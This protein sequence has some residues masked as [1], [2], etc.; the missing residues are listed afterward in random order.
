MTGI[1]C[2]LAG[3]SGSTGT[4][5]SVTFTSNGTWVAPA[6]VSTVVS[7]SGKGAAGVSDYGDSTGGLY[8]A[9]QTGSA[10]NAPY[11][12]WGTAYA[13]YQTALS[14]I[15]GPS[16]PGYGPSTFLDFD[17][18]FI[19]PSD[20]WGRINSTT[21][22]SGIYVTGYSNYTVGSPPTS[23][24]I[25]YAGIGGTISG[26]GI[27]V[28]IIAAGGTGAASTAL[29]QTFPGGS[30]TGS[31]PNGVGNAAVTTTYTN[32]AVTPGT[33]YSIVVPSGGEVTLQYYV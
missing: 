7:A 19:D 3:G 21:N 32:I 12:Q 13:S 20:R 18:F 30:Y 28:N 5:T 24:N 4:L 10:A 25:T 23:G 14:Q 33:S 6:G 8:C 31:Y 17:A 9:V 1:T 16:Y 15:S 29:G 11:A 26:W 22:L 27:T 2:A